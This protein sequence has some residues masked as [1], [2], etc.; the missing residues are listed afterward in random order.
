MWEICH[1]IP[2]GRPF[3][4][5]PLQDL[6]CPEC[7]FACPFQPVLQSGQG[8]AK[9]RWFC[10]RELHLWASVFLLQWLRV[11]RLS[12]LDR[13]TEVRVEARLP[14]R[15][16]FGLRP[17]SYSFSRVVLWLEQ[18]GMSANVKALEPNS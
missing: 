18:N 16:C 5:E 9:D 3:F 2:G 1:I 14:G 11:G 17:Q 15:A 4:V 6:L 7:W 13:E 10:W 12:R 8:L